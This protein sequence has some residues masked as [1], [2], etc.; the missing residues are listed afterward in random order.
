MHKALAEQ[1][2]FPFEDFRPI[3]AKFV[4]AVS[5]TIKQGK[6]LLVH[7]PTGIGKT[8]STLSPAVTYALEHKKTVFFLTSRHTQH[9]IALETL[10]LLQNKHDKRFGVVNLVGKQNMCLQPGVQYL[11]SSE[12]HSYCKQQREQRTCSYFNKTRK[13][14]GTLDVH[15]TACTEQLANH[16]IPLELLK[17]SAGDLAVCP[18]EIALELSKDAKVIVADYNY[19]FNDV[20]RNGFFRRTELELQDCI[21]IVDEAHNLPSRIKN[22]ATDRLTSRT[23][24]LAM[25]EA[26][27][28][29]EPKAQQYVTELHV[30]FDSYLD[31]D[32]DEKLVPKQFFLAMIEEIADIDAFTEE[33][34]AA[35]ERV[36]DDKKSSFLLSIVE[37]ITRWKGA[38]KGFARIMSKKQGNQGTSIQLSYTCLDPALITTPILD[39]CH[40][41]IFMSGTLQPLDMYQHLLGAHD[42]TPL[43]F[44]NPFPIK[45]RLSLVVPKTTTKFSQR[46]DKQFEDI[47]QAVTDIVTNIPGNSI[48]FLPSYQIHSRISAILHQKCPRTIM[49]EQQGMHADER[50]QLLE[51]FKSYAQQGGAV[52]LAVSS[53]SFGEGIDLPGDLL[54]GVIIVG[55]PLARPDLEVKELIAYYQ[56]TYGRGWDYGY[57]LPAFNIIIQN[58]GRCIRSAQDRGVIVYLDERF[59]QQFKSYFPEAVTVD[60]IHYVDRVKE[61]FNNDINS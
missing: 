51:N 20:V 6:Q 29:G 60:G 43:A 22:M 11:S 59:G 47:A 14:S 52:L 54:K 27:K 8:A 28:A 46:N 39:Q 38:D 44:D 19:I 55:V 50:K 42:A 18:Y 56:T 10:Q 58:A 16:I 9:L 45:N 2:L 15:G 30:M 31:E 57:L 13:T 17:S 53:G 24:S 33:L 25:K 7:A 61:F 3:Q 12:F 32:F 49:T 41:V 36:R 40:S 5:A 4:A 21:V 1:H 26:E 48:I 35:G 34:T 23:L 37:F